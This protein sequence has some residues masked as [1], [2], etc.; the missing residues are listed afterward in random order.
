MDLATLIGFLAAILGTICWVPQLVKVLRSR[1]VEDL[2]MG[3][4]LLLLSTI[5]LWLIYGILLKEW[6]LILANLFSICC[7]G[8]IVWAK[9]IWGKR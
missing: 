2:S 5:T 4:N 3:T 9:I 6:P 1:Q 8:T 7:V